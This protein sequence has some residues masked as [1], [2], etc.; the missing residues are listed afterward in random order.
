MI[1]VN[2][3][4]DNC[5]YMY[6]VSQVAVVGCL[7]ECAWF[8][9]QFVLVMI[10]INITNTFVFTGINIIRHIVGEKLNKHCSIGK[11]KSSNVY[12]CNNTLYC[13]YMSI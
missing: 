11:N 4:I 13:M 10:A 9:P 5:L 7:H 6:M 3:D 8:I 12:M 2:V 1:Q